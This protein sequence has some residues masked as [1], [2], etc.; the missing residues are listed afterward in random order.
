MLWNMYFLLNIAI[1]FGIRLVNFFR[2]GWWYLNLRSLLG[3]ITSNLPPIPKPSE[4]AEAYGINLA[5]IMVVELGNGTVES[6]N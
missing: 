5:S 4:L 3:S 6:D 1:L 2:C